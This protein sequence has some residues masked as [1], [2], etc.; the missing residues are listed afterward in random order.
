M[1]SLKTK[2]RNTNF[3]TSDNNYSLDKTEEIK[4]EEKINKNK[5]NNNLS[6]KTQKRM[7]AWCGECYQFFEFGPFAKVCQQHVLKKNCNVY[8]CKKKYIN[9]NHSIKCIRKFPNINSENRHTYCTDEDEVKNWDPKMKIQNYILNYNNIC[10]SSEKNLIS[11]SD[12]YSKNSF[13]SMKFSDLNLDLLEETQNN[14]IN[15]KHN[16]ICKININSNINSNK[17]IINNKITVKKFCKG[18]DNDYFQSPSNICNVKNKERENLNIK[19]SNCFNLKTLSFTYKD[20]K[21]P[22]FKYSNLEEDQESLK[23]TKNLFPDLNHVRDKDIKNTA[24]HINNKNEIKFDKKFI[25]KEKTKKRNVLKKTFKYMDNLDSLNNIDEIDKEFNSNNNLFKANS[26]S[27]EKSVKNLE[28]SKKFSDLNLAILIDTNTLNDKK[29]K[30]ILRKKSLNSE[31]TTSHNKESLVNVNRLIDQI[32]NLKFENSKNDSILEDEILIKQFDNI[33]FN[34]NKN[35]KDCEIISLNNSHL[36]ILNSKINR[37]EENIDFLNNSNYELFNFN[38]DKNFS[39]FDI[40]NFQSN[41]ILENDLNDKLFIPGKINDNTTEENLNHK[42]NVYDKSTSSKNYIYKVS[43]KNE[44]FETKKFDNEKFIIKNTSQ[45]EFPSIYKRKPF[46]E[47]EIKIEN[48]ENFN[49]YS[50]CINNI[51]KLN[52]NKENKKIFK[53]SDETHIDEIFKVIHQNF[54]I[55]CKIINRVKDSMKKKGIFNARVLRLFKK[56]K[57]GWNFIK[58]D[59]SKNCSQIEAIAIFLEEVLEEA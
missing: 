14:N 17:N 55:P 11:S 39:K 10:S 1:S 50:S 32:G 15:N 45:I 34:Y 7:R 31:N 27:N 24:K 26:N 21:N 18:N 28:N 30:E 33:Y 57:S 36:D 44:N 5:G 47:D 12:I 9:S 23:I 59:F 41:K 2:E 51:N 53:I 43:I 16:N 38:S 3:S 13:D 48:L 19:K 4:S 20:S 6:N 8:E 42:Y 35:K 54:D 46:N 58:K 49:V 52:E 22:E 40:N 56:K 37:I 25:L 29:N